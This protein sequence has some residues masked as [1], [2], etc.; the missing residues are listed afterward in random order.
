M[1]EYCI[2]HG[3]VQHFLGEVDE[4]II[5]DDGDEE[6]FEGEALHCCLCHP[7]HP[8]NPKLGNKSLINISIVIAHET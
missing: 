2:E 4:I 3:Y 5:D 7:N 1:I 6:V 8:D